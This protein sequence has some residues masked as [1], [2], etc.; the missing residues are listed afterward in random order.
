M[1]PAIDAL[2][3]AGDGAG[4]LAAQEGDAAGEL[5]RRAEAADGDFGDDLFQ[6]R[7]GDRGDHVGVDIAGGDRVDRHALLGAFLRERLGE[8]VDARF[9]GGL[10]DLAILA[11]LDFDRA[12][13]AD[14]APPALD[15]AETARFPHGEVAEP[16]DTHHTVTI[17]Y[18]PPHHG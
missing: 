9:G 10:I 4:V 1:V 2:R 7:G 14:P 5:A 8:A 13:V 6:H 17:I 18:H 12:D 16:D 11:R 3:R 15:H